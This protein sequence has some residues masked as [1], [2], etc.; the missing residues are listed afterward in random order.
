M[1]LAD[2]AA[3][4]SSLLLG[5]NVKQANWGDD[6]TTRYPQTRMGV[7]QLMRD[8]FEAARHYR[9]RA[10]EQWQQTGRGLPPRR[11]LE[12]DAIAEILE[13]TSLDPLPQL[14]PG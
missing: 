13:G 6:H 9:R 7:E 14:P 2:R 4:A 8:A 12:L 11:D 1:K 3:A 5:E 10:V